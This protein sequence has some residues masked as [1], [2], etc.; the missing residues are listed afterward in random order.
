MKK[1]KNDFQLIRVAV[2]VLLLFTVACN[3]PSHRPVNDEEFQILLAKSKK[4]SEHYPDSAL[5]ILREL[6]LQQQGAET[7]VN[8]AWVLNLMGTLYDIKGMYDSAAYY[9]YEASRLAEK[10]KND[11]LQTSVYT[12]L[13]VL[14]F[15]LSNAD[16]AIKYYRQA[17]AIAEKRKDSIPIAHL[18]NNIGNTYL[19][20]TH[21]LEKAIPYL[22]QCMEISA[23]TNH[24]LAYKVAG[25]NLAQIYNELGETDKALY[26]IK[27][28]TEQYGGNIY[29]EFTL[30]EI[31]FKKG[32]YR[33]SAHTFKELLK[34]PLNTR[35]FEL[36][37]LKNL[38]EVYKQAG[39][40]DST[41]VY[42]EKSYALRDSLHSQQTG[43]TIHNLKIAY[44]T[45]KKEMRIT[46]L[47]EEKRMI[48]WLSISGSFILL[49]ALLAFFFLWRWTVQKKQLAE[50][51]IKQ[52]EQEKQLV[53][54][55]AILDGETRERTRL[56]R[57]LHDGLGSILTGAKLSLLEMKKGATLEYT[58][59]ARFDQTLGLL[60][61]SI[62]EMRRVAHH[63]M[64]DSLSRLGLKPAVD[65]FCRTLSPN[66]IFD[67]FGD[68]VRLDPKLEIV[69]YRSI[70]ELVNNA[71][72]HSG[73]SQ[74]MVQIM[75]ESD[76]IAFT[77]QDDG[78][79][80]DPAAETW[81]TGLQNI[82]NRIDSLSGNIQID[83]KAGE[84]TEIN[85][86]LR[87]TVVR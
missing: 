40:L 84:G 58:D 63:L 54:T 42:L 13:G 68:E 8:H 72:K 43:E 53:A 25:I 80:F 47:E 39:N 74:I 5:M 18:L 66:I 76:R 45:E 2:V 51:R 19:T 31:Y 41:V 50:A 65:D 69:I 61:E 1:T 62:L 10:I 7:T 77:V 26:E 34:K 44:E 81:G 20:I 75:Q 64:P 49:L 57:D 82:R 29:A 17:L 79:G 27:R 73:A 35:E 86:E 59:V 70:H 28:L 78:C 4:Y 85:I 55:Q 21:E 6:L 37:I 12:N 14:Q 56:A 71:L 30:G 87:N 38:A 33:E 22:Q 83:S 67:Y 15:E 60:D 46:S 9:L 11:S 36:A 23:K 16:E 32:N 48:L 52:F 24:P 3:K